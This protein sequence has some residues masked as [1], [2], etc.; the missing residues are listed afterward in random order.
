MQILAKSKGGRC[1]SKK[2]INNATN[3]KWSCDKHHIWYARPNNIQFG[4]WCPFCSGRCIIKPLKKLKKLA[5]D[6]GGKCLSEKYI[7]SKFKHKWK[8]KEGHIWKATPHDIKRGSWCPMCWNKRK[9]TYKNGITAK[10]T[11]EEM[12]ELAVNKNGVCLSKKYINNETKLLWKCKEGHIWKATPSNIKHGR[13]CPDC[14][15]YKSE[16]LCREYLTTK[17]DKKFKKCK[18]KWLK[19]LE[20]DGYNEELQLAFE[21]N[22]KQHNTYIPYFHK[23]K[24]KFHIAKKRDIM[25][26]KLCKINEIN[27][28]IIPDK[29]NCYNPNKM[30]EYIDSQLS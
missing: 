1:I 21:Y 16:N 30:Y 10:L 20:L 28:I 25:K 26:K 19:G 22:G 13:W 24:K 5:K 15:S 18:P 27:L 3:L 17:F 4:K 29:Y 9:N 14:Y 12:K 11:I 8:C 2:Y 6:K 7:N 23:T